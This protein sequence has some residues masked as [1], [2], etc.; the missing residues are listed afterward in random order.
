MTHLHMK[1][2]AHWR[3]EYGAWTRD[4]ARRVRFLRRL[5]GLMNQ[6]TAHSVGLVL[7]AREY[8]EVDYYFRLRE[9]FG[10]PYSLAV[11][12]AVVL[13]KLWTDSRCPGQQLAVFV[14]HG[15]HGQGELL[16]AIQRL[17]TG[18]RVT[19]LRKKSREG[20][21]VRYCL[22]FQACDFLAWEL[23]KAAATSLS[24]DSVVIRAR[25]SLA[26]I[27][28]QGPSFLWRHFRAD[29]LLTLCRNLRIPR[30]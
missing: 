10:G 15:D 16:D 3:G 28:P 25:K 19:V 17:K 30:R 20:A 4:E 9:T 26:Q 14:E 11:F 8:K 2:L 23:R 12:A 22:P 18:V 29:H 1:D 21:G 13:V 5:T 6:H 24:E 7:F 27:A